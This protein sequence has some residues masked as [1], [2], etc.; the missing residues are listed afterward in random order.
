MLHIEKWAE[1]RPR[2]LAAFAHSFATFSDLLMALLQAIISG[3]FSFEEYPAVPL[4]QWLGFYK[5]H[6]RIWAAMLNLL[7]EDG[8]AEL[9]L[10]NAIDNFGRQDNSLNDFEWMASEHHAVFDDFYR[11]NLDRIQA[12]IQSKHLPKSGRSADQDFTKA[13]ENPAI[14]FLFRVWLPCYFLYG[15]TPPLLLRQARQGNAQAVDRLLR[16]DKSAIFDPKI[17]R[18][19]HLAAGQQPR[20]FEQLID[21]LKKPPK[22]IIQKRKIKVSLAAFISV[23]F[24]D[25][26]YKL[27]EPEIRALFD[28]VAKDQGHG[29]IDTD[30]PESPHAFYMAI[31]RELPFWEQALKSHK[32]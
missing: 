27:E 21:A 5:S 17:A 9:D 2:L 3:K 16:L 32:K 26:G 10:L 25:C 1:G 30:L 4:E 8:A 11:Q 28:A 31:Q 29:E 18:Q 22:G 13:P 14:H 6:R 12:D 15:T 23:I 20:Q 7:G 19:F 24:E